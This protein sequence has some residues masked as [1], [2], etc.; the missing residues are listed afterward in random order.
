MPSATQGE[1]PAQ[2]GCLGGGPRRPLREGIKPTHVADANG[3]LAITQLSRSVYP[4]VG[5]CAGPVPFGWMNGALLPVMVTIAFSN[6]SW[7]SRS[8]R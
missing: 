4:D 6:R 7:T 5:G 8:A 2:L 3:I 1:W